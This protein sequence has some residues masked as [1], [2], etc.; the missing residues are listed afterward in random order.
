MSEQLFVLAGFTMARAVWSISTGA[1]L[2][3]FGVAEGPSGA[4]KIVRFVSER[5]EEAARA[6]REWLA[7]Q[8]AEGNR[9][10]I[11]FEGYFTVAGVRREAL[12]LEANESPQ[13]RF[14]VALQYSRDAND[15]A[16]RI[17]RPQFIPS[18]GTSIDA[19]LADKAF[20]QG[21]ESEEEGSAA[22]KASQDEG[23]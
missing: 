1:D 5:F 21:V 19:D 11:V 4:R 13:D 7:Q 16:L 8:Q 9:A 17:Y 20:F 15:S 6:A 18:S 3:A 2:I 22:W 12:I 14:T 23:P 10:A